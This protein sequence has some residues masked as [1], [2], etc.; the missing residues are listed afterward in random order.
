MERATRFA[1]IVDDDAQSRKALARLM[2]TL[3]FRTSLYDSGEAFLDSETSHRF[4]FIL[5]DYHFPGLGGVD[6]LRQVRKRHPC[7]CLVVFTGREVE[8][9]RQACLA[10]GASGFL[11]K[12][13]GRDNLAPYL[14]PGRN[15]RA[16]LAK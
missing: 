4:D 3:N 10:G 11:A 7:A 16:I 12:P 5:L 13:I 9:A 15:P 8:F 2:N 14:H 1:A 6:L